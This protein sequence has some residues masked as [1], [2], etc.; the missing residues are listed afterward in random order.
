LEAYL[1]PAQED[2][3]QPPQPELPEGAAGPELDD[4]PI[5]KRDISFSVLFDPHL[6]HTT[7]AFDPKTSFSKSARQALQ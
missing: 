2:E 1:H 4:L 3:E 7:S 5:P 6:S